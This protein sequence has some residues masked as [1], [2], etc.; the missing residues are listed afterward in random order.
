MGWDVFVRRDQHTYCLSFSEQDLKNFLRFFVHTYPF[1]P[2]SLWTTNYVYLH[3]FLIYPPARNYP[4]S[5]LP[6]LTLPIPHDLII[7]FA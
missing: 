6:Y 7:R 4:I 2:L 1:F 5:H 3:F